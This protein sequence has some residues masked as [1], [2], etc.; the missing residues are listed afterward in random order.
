MQQCFGSDFHTNQQAA[1]NAHR[2]LEQTLTF[3][4]QSFDGA[5]V[6]DTL[7][8]LVSPLL[9]DMVAKL[10]RVMRPGAPILGFFSAQEKTNLV[11]V[12]SYR[13]QDSKTVLQTARGT[14]QRCE[15]FNNRRLEKLFERSSSVKFFLTRGAQREVIV[16]R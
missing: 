16:R 14:P 11:P 7:Q 15:Y 2:F 12:Y 5:L 10:F 3:P 13:I 1:S 8:L 4:D 9:E 6:W